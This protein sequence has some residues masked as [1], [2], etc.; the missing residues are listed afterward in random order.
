MANLI[1]ITDVTKSYF[2]HKV[3]DNV[4]LGINAG[5]F[6]ALL[7]KNGA[8]KSTLMRILMRH[9]APDFGGGLAFGIPFSGSDQ[10]VNHQIAYVSETIDIQVSSNISDF[11]KSYAKFFR[12]WDQELFDSFISRF[13]VDPKKR[14]Q[15][16]SRGQKMQIAFAAAVAI[17]PKVLFLDEITSVLDA[18]A[19]A[20]V[21]EYLG[22]F[23]KAGGSVVMA[24][25]LVSEVER[26]V[27]HIWLIENKKIQINQS[28]KDVKNHYVKLRRL[29]GS[30]N[31]FFQTPHC[32]SV[33]L[34][35][36]ASESYIMVRS[37]FE[38]A[39][40]ENAETLMDKRAITT[41]ELF[42]YFTRDRGVAS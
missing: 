36:D 34:N 18:S 4:S 24:T 17:K 41:E 25:N 11:Y 21:M 15:Q 42:I 8:G 22:A 3:L 5:V 7:G 29:A 28:I 2:K 33:G 30:Q 26:Y 37:K 13:K 6:Y 1:Q 31:P 38:A 12:N 16:F 40:L 27:D 20:Y 9:E 10:E 19:R 39:R 35:S 14:F 23:C 32:I